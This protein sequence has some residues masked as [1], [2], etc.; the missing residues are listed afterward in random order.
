MT[1]FSRSTEKSLAPWQE[2]AHDEG[3]AERDEDAFYQKDRVVTPAEESE[4]DDDS[5]HVDFAK[6]GEEPFG[7]NG[8][9]GD[10]RSEGGDETGDFAT[11]RRVGLAEFCGEKGFFCGDEAELE[12]CDREN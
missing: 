10:S 9:S 12:E 8:G 4:A 2:S 3:D 5:P 1:I 11:V 7:L 6:E